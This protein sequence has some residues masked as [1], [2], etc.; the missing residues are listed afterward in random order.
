MAKKSTKQQQKPQNQQQ[1]QQQSHH[2]HQ[3]Q[4]KRV[5]L[6]EAEVTELSDGHSHCLV[7]YGDLTFRG[8]IP[9]GHDDICGVCHLRLRYLHNDTKCPICKQS[10]EETVD[11]GTTAAA[12]DGDGIGPDGDTGGGVGGSG[13][14]VIVDRDPEKKHA[15][16]ARWGDD[17]G[18]GYIHRK[19]VGMFFQEDYY[20][21]EV[22]PLFAYACNMCDF[23]VDQNTR[24]GSTQG[25]GKKNSPQRLLL[26]HLRTDHRLAM[27]YLCI[28][29]KRDFIS[30]LP[31]FSP[32]QLQKHLKNGDGPESGFNGHPMCVFCKPKRFYDNYHLHQHLHKEHYK[33]HI[34]EKQGRDN[35]WFKHYG[36]LQRHFDQQHFLCHNPQCLE[37]RFVVF[38]NEL[39]LRAHELSVHGG[40]STGSTKINLEFR[41]RRQGYDGSGMD[42]GHQT[43]PDDSDFNYDLDG[44]A[45]VPEALS[46]QSGNETTRGNT[47]D[48]MTTGNTPSEQLHPLHVQRT[49]ALREH[50]AEVRRQ[51]ALESQVESFPTLQ[52]PSAASTS[53]SAP[54][55]GWASGSGL[56]RVN[57]QTSRNRVG[58]VTEESFPA[59]PAT[60]ANKN[61][62]KNSIRAN[63]GATRRQFAAMS[64]TAN[65]PTH[66]AASWGGGSAASPAAAM[67]SSTSSTRIANVH[68]VP[69]VSGNRQSDLTADNFPALGPSST[70]ARSHTFSTVNTSATR[71]VQTV[72]STPPS[73][74][75]MAD[76]PSMAP[77]A[78]TSNATKKKPAT[79]AQRQQQSMP[80]LNNNVDFPP[81]PSASQSHATVRQQV[82][83]GGVSRQHG[84]DNTL[85]VDV[86]TA[87]KATV[88]DMKA[89][90][91][92]KKFKQLK[93]LTREFADG[94]LSAEGYVDRS[95]V[96]FDRG[97]ADP[98]FWGFLPSLLESCP[99]EASSQ[100]ALNYMSSLKRRQFSTAPNVKAPSVG[101]SP[102]PPATS[103]GGPSA[104]ASI[105]RPPPL[106]APGSLGKSTAPQVSHQYSNP[107]RPAA[108]SFPKPIQTNKKSAWGAGGTTSVVRAKAPPGSVS[109][110]AASQGPQ[111]GT[112][113]KYMAKDHKQQQQQQQQQLQAS[114]TN[115][116]KKKKK[117]QNDELRALAF[118]R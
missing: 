16:Y 38:E 46:S 32:S 75:S 50:A 43:A 80:S 85:N 73:F 27:C 74:S 47:R 89:S 76:F 115:N 77:T 93:R 102:P 6:S 14:G 86:S 19:D 108:S 2:H 62:K 60:Q 5:S 7:C 39:D 79:Q 34:C 82:S 105:M 92:Q 20:Q 33:C 21:T 97:Y 117:K 91:G 118:G 101:S 25:G 53:S 68:A 112:A 12:A 64:A 58:R 52:A 96:L 99:N 106:N 48:S 29:H 104:S 15:D 81:P 49:E 100:N 44:Q 24:S 11:G 94:E 42:D 116:G 61:A 4:Q 72:N 95:A 110:A 71:N 54:L 69:Q 26:D 31:R 37:A 55:V 36:S 28:D 63:S 51:Q 84:T 57:H 56:E 35:Q 107:G 1:Q 13:G 18:S 45:F 41:T 109:A 88:D 59:L 78:P 65:Q 9:C 67:P 30:Q 70:A 98:D 3:Q 103:W 114:N 22:V 17:I 111:A 66:T 8:K 90:L 113:T 10:T 40:T 83:L 23:Q 87:A